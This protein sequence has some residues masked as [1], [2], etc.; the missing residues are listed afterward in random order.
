VKRILFILIVL[1]AA[2][3]AGGAWWWGR[4]SLPPLNGEAR[5]PGLAGPVEVLFDEWG[6]PHVYATGPE[7]AWAAAGTLHARD[8]LWQMEL[9]RRA[10]YGRLSEVLGE[11]TLPVDKR[12]L[13]LGIKEAAH[14]EWQAADPGVRAALLRYAEGVNAQ[15]SRAVGRFKP[16]EFQI[17]RFDPAPWTPI[18]SLAVGRL[19][20]W[21]LAENHHSELV[22]HALASKFGAAEANRL[23]GSYPPDAPTVLSPTA[24]P[25]VGSSTYVP[26]VGSTGVLEAGVL[27][28]GTA[29]TNPREPTSGTHV[30]NPRKEPPWPA[31]LEWLRPAGRGLSNNFVVSGS[32]TTTGRPLLANDPHLQIEF[33]SVWYEMHLVAAGLDVMGVTIP[34]TPFVIIGHNQHI[35]W[36]VT[37]TGADVQDLYVERLDLNRR[38]YL[39]RG[40][41][42]PIDITT[43]DIPVRGRAAEPFEIWRTRH[44]TVFAEVGSLDWRAPPAWLT[45]GAERLGERRAFTLRW[46]I[47]GEMAGAFEALDRAANWDEFVAAVERFT[48]PSQNFVF[49]DVDG[50]IGYAMSGVLPLRSNGNGT[51]PVDGAGGEGEWIGRV[52][53]ATL[54]RALNPKIGYITSSNNE[55][56]RQ[57][58]GLITHDWAAPF[59]A[60]RLHQA[61]TF[62]EKWGLSSASQLQ[63]DNVSV[64]AEQILGGVDAAVA[65]GKAVGASEVA[66]RTLEQLRAW[67]RRVDARPVVALFQAFEDALWRRTFADEMGPELFDAFYE[68]AGAE[69]PAGLYAV[70]GDS[71]SKWFDDI[72]TIDRRETRNQIYLL[73]ARD[74]VDR[75]EREYGRQDEWNW[76]R[77][78]AAVFTHALST[79]GFPLRW[80]FDGG[81]SEL[82]GDGTTV[83]R[84]SHNRLAPFRAWELPSW[85]QVLDVG[86]WDDSRVVLPAGQSG[87][88]L[89]PHYFDQNE[90]WRQ[91]LYRSQ[92]FTRAAV[93]RARAHRLLLMP[94]S[95]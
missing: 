13:T 69:R 38:R 86:G 91:G 16:L 28:A 76:G 44:G 52:D 7:D 1:L 90:L 54:P 73:A 24:V 93:D 61:L 41:W 45:R 30:R 71:D 35:A 72:G 14:A 77:M 60:M 31:G 74:A 34:G 26:S 88:P 43:A 85:R 68:W 33:P 21:R 66:L 40:Q 67:D 6:V 47:S 27:T 48:A 4:Q 95:P 83:M 94:A 50:N 2:G 75:L 29:V 3:A 82:T 11:R 17:L 39:S 22:R 51:S 89:S 84:V 53:P 49:A 70:L 5:L 55:V 57:W 15:I 65:A 10:A 80:L 46:D 42:V 78:H 58:R 37:N 25:H 59:R 19:L 18:D 81:V 63:M 64:A 56:D 12:F 62:T 8:R 92:P 79:G 23:A 87:H 20:A 36:G 9:Y 32:R